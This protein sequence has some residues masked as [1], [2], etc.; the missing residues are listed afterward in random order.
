LVCSD[1]ILSQDEGIFMKR[2]WWGW[3][4]KVLI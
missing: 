2:E 3:H 1:S 4:I